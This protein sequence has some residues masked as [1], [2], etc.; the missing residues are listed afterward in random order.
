MSLSFSHAMMYS[1]R[2]RPIRNIP[3]V[4]HN[5]PSDA[6]WPL[7]AAYKMLWEGERCRMQ[8]WWVKECTSDGL[9]PSLIGGN[10]CYHWLT[11][12][13]K[14]DSSS[15]LSCKLQ[16]IL[17]LTVN[18]IGWGKLASGPHT[19]SGSSSCIREMEELGITPACPLILQLHWPS[20]DSNQECNFLS[21]YCRGCGLS[22][23]FSFWAAESHLSVYAD[24]SRNASKERSFSLKSYR[25]K[26]P[27]KIYIKQ[28]VPLGTMFLYV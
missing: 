25:I 15:N 18:E 21:Q 1:L 23:S 27:F 5:Q 8:G 13:L 7:T 28:T 26:F 19:I 3:Q 12:Y 24:G 22:S 14:P 9:R 10:H 6:H 17:P 11:T 20:C 16:G 4:V 2:I